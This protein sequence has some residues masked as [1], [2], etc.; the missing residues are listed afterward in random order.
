[1]ADWLEAWRRVV[2]LNPGTYSEE[3]KFLA[4]ID[5]LIEQNWSRYGR[6]MG[7]AR[8]AADSQDIN[9]GPDLF[10]ALCRENA[11]L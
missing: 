6:G 2:D 5:E 3:G 1:M 8:R 9:S 4:V 7:Y 10:F 11:D